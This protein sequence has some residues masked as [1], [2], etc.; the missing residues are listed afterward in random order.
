MKNLGRCSC[1]VIVPLMTYLFEV[2]TDFHSKGLDIKSGLAKRALKKYQ[3]NGL[4]Q[5]SFCMYA[6]F[7]KTRTSLHQCRD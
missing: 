5:A 2:F 1:L 3:F 4:L 7:K 6:G